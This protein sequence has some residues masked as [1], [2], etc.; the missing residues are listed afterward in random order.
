MKKIFSEDYYLGLDCGT[1]SVGWAVTDKSYNVLDFHGK[2]MWGVRLFSEAGTAEERRMFRTARRRRD[3]E[4]Q[5]IQWLQSIFDEEIS[6]I[7]PGFFQRMKESAFWADD[8]TEYQTN[9]L[10]NDKGSG[11]GPLNDKEYHRL[12]P[13]IYHL[14]KDLIENKKPPYD[15]RLVYLAIHHIMKKRGHFLYDSE[16]S[17]TPDLSIVLDQMSAILNDSLGLEIS[18]ERINIEELGK[19]L[20]EKTSITEKKKK[21]AGF[22]GI[23]EKD[24]QQKAVA[25]L[26]AGG[27]A[28]LSDLLCDESIENEALNSFSFQDVNFEEVQN[29][30]E[31]LLQDNF[32]CLTSI[33]AVYDWGILARVLGKASSISFAKVNLFEKHKADL[34]VLKD[35]VKEYA[36]ERYPEVFLYV[37][38]SKAS[39]GTACS[40]FSAA[41][42]DNESLNNYCSYIGRSLK[43]HRKLTVFKTCSFDQFKDFLLKDILEKAMKD[44]PS[45]PRLSY[46]KVELENRTFLPKL[47]T[48]E[49]SIVPRQL[50]EIELKSILENASLYLPFLSRKDKDGLTVTEKI[51]RLF[52]FR[53]PYYVGPLNGIV[54]NTKGERTNW[55]VKNSNKKITPYNFEKMVDFE[56]S[57]EGFI[58]RMTS[59]CTYLTK[60]DVLPKNSLLFSKFSVLNE[61]NNLTIRGRKINQELKILIYHELFETTKK[62]TKKKI[63]ALLT[64][65]GQEV[66]DFDIAG[67]DG[68]FKSS[69]SSYLDFKEF[70]D[71]GRLT[72][73]QV[74]EII[75]WIVLFGDSKSI[76]RSKIKKAFPDLKLSDEEFKSILSKKYTGW[77]RL[78]EKF[79]NLCAPHPETGEM[80]SVIRALEEL[81]ENPNLMQLLS[82]RFDYLEA[83]S[84]ENNLAQIEKL[85]YSLVEELCVSPVVKRQ[86]W[87]TLCIVDELIKILGKPP[88]KVFI[89]VSKPVHKDKGKRTISRLTTMKDL[90]NGIKESELVNQVVQVQE[91]SGIKDSLSTQTDEKMRIDKLFLYYSQMGR[92]MYSGDV[93]RLEK[94]FTN[95]YDIDHIFP[96]SIIK[97]DS[98]LNNRVLVNRIQNADKKDVFPI[99]SDVQMKRKGFWSFLLEKNLISR[100][101]YDRLIRTEPLSDEELA[102]F[103]QRQMVENR[104]SIKAVA[105]ILEGF[106]G[107]DSDVV[108][109][110]ANLASDFRKKFD[111][112]KCR[113]INDLHHAKDAYL[114]IVAGNVYDT[115]FTKN[116]LN[117][118]KDPEQSE[119]G[120]EENKKKEQFKYNLNTIYRQSVCRNRIVAWEK[121]PEGT[122]KTVRKY[123]NRS[124]VQ[125][126]RLSFDQKGGFY[127]QMLVKKGTNEGLVPIK[128]V[129]SSPFIDTSRYGGYNKVAGNYFFIVDHSDKKGKI[130]RSIEIAPLHLSKQL[131]E[132]G[133]LQRYCRERLGYENPRVV[134]PHLKYQSL[135]EI[136]GF[137]VFIAGKS[138]NQIILHGASPLSA[139]IETNNFFHYVTKY[140]NDA[141]PTAMAIQAK[142]SK[143]S[144]NEAEMTLEDLEQKMEN[145]VPVKKDK[146]GER[147]TSLISDQKLDEAYKWFVK[148][149]SEKPFCLRPNS[150]GQNLE[151][152]KENFFSLSLY[153]KCVVLTN[154]MLLFGCSSETSADLRSINGIANAG[155]MK[156]GKNMGKGVSFKIIN[157]SV[158]GLFSKTQ[159]ISL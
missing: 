67:I 24:K 35:A 26:L 138:N 158:T 36:P 61:L 59:K 34:Q 73:S 58:R 72:E 114:N 40:P 104:Q 109:V 93:I 28:K 106:F 16:F 128:S 83:I 123:M 125:F 92:C 12:F 51:I 69:L 113:E 53:I 126:T 76:L 9:S 63:V 135:L 137:P 146:R 10:F 20:Q 66:R 81:P 117:F 11:K 48:V 25:Y 68:D 78:S 124:N 57:A 133:E 115:K 75:K 144:S 88:K 6:K 62:V 22:F 147:I 80:I 100:V 79:L 17:S 122:I 13:S 140:I 108:F 139:D 46:I 55:V 37:R 87:Q 121:G 96:Q 42:K 107:S 52:E 29:D 154:I 47:A 105:E 130:I 5:R 151:K 90:Y 153:Y 110:K 120:I 111:M 7:D 2:G 77:G 8:K 119:D 148:K 141:K 103:I 136:N 97:D 85:D 127:D 64:N 4:N 131:S 43:N 91:F 98:I 65:M 82:K 38:K 33:K 30:L 41:T 145:L 134:V 49:N 159:D 56:G 74:E 54:K 157:Q 70:L 86:I 19:S 152:L 112:L 32:S 3:R 155:S 71:S 45:D 142:L 23:D 31:N 89:E 84:L 21:I 39:N 27:K 143:E 129:G 156:L 116:P 44:N 132:E 50:N 102:S 94:L 101:K 18:C 149:A 60:E 15:V 150:Q 118:L 14:R 99:D 95:E 1:N